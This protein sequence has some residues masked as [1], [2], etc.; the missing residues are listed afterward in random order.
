M[1]KMQKKPVVAGMDPGGCD[2]SP[3]SVSFTH[4]RLLG[5]HLN[6]SCF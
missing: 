4:F 1:S 3:R 5:V 2:F 6:L